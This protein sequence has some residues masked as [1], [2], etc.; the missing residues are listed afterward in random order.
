MKA[1]RC[2]ATIQKHRAFRAHGAQTKWYRHNDTSWQN[3]LLPL[4]KELD[5]NDYKDIIRNRNGTYSAELNQHF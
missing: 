4:P 2:S 1:F 5:P 3:N